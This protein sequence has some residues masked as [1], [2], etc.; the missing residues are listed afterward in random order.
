[1][2]IV[3]KALELLKG[4]K[5]K[6]GNPLVFPGEE[7]KTVLIRAYW[8]NALR[9]TGINDFRFHDLRHSCASYLAMNGASMLEIADVL[10]H[11]TLAMVKRYSHLSEAHTTGILTRMNEKIFES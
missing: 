7:G 3:G 2:P 8:E 10:G 4:I 5:R 6:E 1:M 9:S 11:K